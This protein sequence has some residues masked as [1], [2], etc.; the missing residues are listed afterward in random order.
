MYC[1]RGG[2]PEPQQGAGNWSTGAHSGGRKRFHH[3]PRENVT[4]LF[5]VNSNNQTPSSVCLWRRGGVI[6]FRLSP[7]HGSDSVRQSLCVTSIHLLKT[8]H[9]IHLCCMF[10]CETPLS[11]WWSTFTGARRPTQCAHVALLVTSSYRTPHAHS[12]HTTRTPHAHCTDHSILQHRRDFRAFC[13]QRKRGLP[14]A[15]LP[16][17]PLPPLLQ[18]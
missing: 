6:R 4:S 2:R 1:C 16:T 18:G 15:A 12:R 8:T 13:R 14:G 17:S 7:A 11:H 10:T 3:S 5:T 9:V